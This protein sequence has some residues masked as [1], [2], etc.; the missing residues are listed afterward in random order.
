MGRPPLAAIQPRRVAV[1][2]PSALGDIVH[3]LPIL[4]ALRDRFPKPT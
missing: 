4:P 3:A 2:K 1:I